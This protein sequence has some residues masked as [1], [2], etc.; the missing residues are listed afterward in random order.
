MRSYSEGVTRLERMGYFE[1]ADRAGIEV[2]FE[3]A[4]C[5]DQYLSYSPPI[6]LAYMRCVIGSQ[7]KTTDYY[8]K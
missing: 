5:I 8:S 6:E 2:S 1:I 4:S 3:L 7:I